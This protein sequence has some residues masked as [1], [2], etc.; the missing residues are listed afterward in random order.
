MRFAV[1]RQMLSRQIIVQNNGILA[2]IVK[3]SAGMGLLLSLGTSVAWADSPSS[4]ERKPS[5]IHVSQHRLSADPFQVERTARAAD[6]GAFQNAPPAF[7]LRTIWSQPLPKE[8]TYAFRQSERST[9]LLEGGQLLLGSSRVKGVLRMDARTGWIESRIETRG[10]L[11]A[12]VERDPASGDLFVG[13]TAGF[14]YRLRT[15]GTKVWEYETTGPVIS[16]LGLGE[17]QVYFHAIDGTLLALDAATGKPLWNYRREAHTTEGLPIFGSST[18]VMSN[19]I[20]IAGYE[21]GHVVGLNAADGSPAWEYLLVDE[22]RWQDVDGQ[23]LVLANDRVVISAYRGATVCLKVSTGEAIW[24][25]NHG[26][27]AQPLASGTRL[28]LPDSD[29]W[30]VA[31]DANTGERLWRWEIPGKVVPLNPVMWRDVLVVTTSDGNLYMLNPEDGQ[32]KYSLATDVL[33]NGFSSPVVPAGDVLFAVTDG[34]Y[35]YAFGAP[36][37]QQ[38]VVDVEAE[39]DVRAMSQDS[40]LL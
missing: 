2:S 3:N 13:D 11:E 5:P 27:G 37:Y 21:D 34:G 30:V 4:E 14:V 33:L 29:G 12:P 26:G 6:T 39:H 23:P 32:L 38:P 28:Y 10:G 15:D 24:R 36:D 18:P 20:V 31:V 7:P 17:G 22:E 8:I 16:R 35:V 25:A 40:P 9:P 1:A 19:G